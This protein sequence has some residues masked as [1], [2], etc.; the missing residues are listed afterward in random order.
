MRDYKDTISSNMD[1]A[2]TVLDIVGTY[3]SLE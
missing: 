1:L 3:G 2:A